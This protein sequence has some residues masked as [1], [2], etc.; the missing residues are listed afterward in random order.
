MTAPLSDMPL[1]DLPLSDGDRLYLRPI[2]G[3]AG[4][5][6][7]AARIAGAWAGF[8]TVEVWARDGSATRRARATVAELRSWARSLASPHDAR[9]DELLQ[10]VTA[11]RADFAGLDMTEPRIMGILNVTPDSFSD[12]GDYASAE[13]AIARGGEQVAGG[14]TILD[15]GGESTR[16]GSDPV[17]EDEELRRVLPVIEALS[18]AATGTVI[19]I[20]SRKAAV[21]RGAVGAGA[22]VINDISALAGDDQALGVAA[23]CG[24]PVIL[25]HCRG[26]PKTMQAAPA[27]DDPVTE[28]YDFLAARIDAC[29]NAGIPRSRIAVDPG[30]GFGK[31]L[32]HNLALL[33]Q[34]SV[35]HG[36]GCPLLL[37]VSRKSFIAQIT[38][39]AQPKA[40]LPGSLA[41]TLAGLNQGVQMVRAHDTAETAQAF[42]V[43]RAIF[44]FGAET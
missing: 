39:E 23:E 12:G 10:A 13:A 14:A 5:D 35:F 6:R 38:G 27:Y 41:A 19:S 26:E 30:I 1:S 8:D 17:A 4:L 2:C 42:A 16:P 37:G 28:V 9:I 21:M 20:D 36:L 44:G 43:W 7:P 22:A 11:P 31:A 18:A 33:A 25:M 29:L 24:V 34:P 40:R 3:A 32:E 15:I